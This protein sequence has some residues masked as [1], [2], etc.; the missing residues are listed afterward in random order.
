MSRA[1]ITSLRQPHLALGL[2]MS[3]GR[4]FEKA[5]RNAW[6]GVFLV[7]SFLAMAV[8]VF[9]MNKAATK[10]YALREQELRLEELKATVANLEDQAARNQ[11][12]YSIESRVQGLGYVPV[13]RMEFL[14]VSRGTYAVAR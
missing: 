12:L 3:K 5:A 7:L 11:A 2:S 9:Q 8:H 6:V 10:G 13:D 14:D 4:K 1:H